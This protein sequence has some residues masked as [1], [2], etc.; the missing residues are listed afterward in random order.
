MADLIYIPRKLAPDIGKYVF[1]IN[2][3]PG[4][5]IGKGWIPLYF[6][7]LAEDRSK[8]RIA[9]EHFFEGIGPTFKMTLE[10]DKPYGTVARH[11]IRSPNSSQLGVF[12][13]RTSFSVFR[14]RCSRCQTFAIFASGSI[15]F[16]H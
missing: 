11:G 4:D 1:H 6:R 13:H 8:I 5:S 10:L 12:D 15:H 14:P 2:Q 7:R 3:I 16:S 9:S